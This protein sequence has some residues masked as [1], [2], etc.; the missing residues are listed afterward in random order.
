MLHYLI[1][2]GD[3]NFARHKTLRLLGVIIPMF[4]LKHGI[5][6]TRYLF[7][8]HQNRYKAGNEENTYLEQWTKHRIC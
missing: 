2:Y 8:K 5:P 6:G 3:I 1:D 7:L 4:A